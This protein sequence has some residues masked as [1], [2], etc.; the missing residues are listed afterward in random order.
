[1]VNVDCMGQCRVFLFHVYTALFG[2]NQIS[3]IFP[4]SKQS[5][6][7]LG[8]SC[9]HVGVGTLYC[10]LIYCRREGGG[11]GGRVQ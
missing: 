7:I 8:V 1:M 6:K 5:C 4:T 10:S 2:S 3:G 11:G 9:F